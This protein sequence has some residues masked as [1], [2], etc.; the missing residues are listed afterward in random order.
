LFFHEKVSLDTFRL[1]KLISFCQ[2]QFRLRS[3]K[4]NQFN[5]NK[6]FNYFAAGLLN[7]E[8]ENK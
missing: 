1:V 6:L 2:P 5:Y 4:N 8:Q 3:N 7:V